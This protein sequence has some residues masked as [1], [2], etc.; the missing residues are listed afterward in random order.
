MRFRRAAPLAALVNPRPVSYIS[1]NEFSHDAELRHEP[2]Q[3]D[4]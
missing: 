4:F 3:S 2:E 1:G